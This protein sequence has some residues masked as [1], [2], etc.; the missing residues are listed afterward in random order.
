MHVI[1]RSSIAAVTGVFQTSSSA[2]IA[3][4]YRRT[5]SSGVARGI[6]ST[7]GFVAPI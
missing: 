3:R 6:A 4:T 5:F 1:S 7:K 2:T